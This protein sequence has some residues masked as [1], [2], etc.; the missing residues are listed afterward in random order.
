MVYTK[1][2]WFST[3]AEAERFEKEML[4]FKSK[5]GKQAYSLKADLVEE[6]VEEPKEV[7]E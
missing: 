6:P 4:E 7:E 1:T 5:G 2:F 3:E